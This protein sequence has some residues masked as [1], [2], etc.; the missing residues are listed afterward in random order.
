MSVSLSDGEYI[1]GRDIAEGHYKITFS[2]DANVKEYEFAL[3]VRIYTSKKDKDEYDRGNGSSS[4]IVIWETFYVTGEYQFYLE[5]GQLFYVAG[6]QKNGS[7][8]IEKFKG[9]FI[10]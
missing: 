7:T 2:P 6:A 4:C 9:L 3:N 5:E 8:H 10:E 1:V